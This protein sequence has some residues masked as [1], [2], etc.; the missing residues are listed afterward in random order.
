MQKELHDVASHIKKLGLAMLA[1]SLRHSLQEYFVSSNST[2]YMDSLGV[3]QAAHACE[4]LIKARIAEK[5]PLLIF[6]KQPKGEVPINLES[7]AKLGK[8]LQ[9]REL[10]KKLLDETGYQIEKS[11]LYQDFGDLRNAIQHFATPQDRDLTQETIEFIFGVIEPLI[12]DSWG[13]YATHHY[14]EDPLDSLGIFPTNYED[15]EPHNDI[16]NILLKL[17]VSFLVSDKYKGQVEKDRQKLETLVNTANFMRKFPEKSL[18][19][20]NDEMI[21]EIKIKFNLS[22]LDAMRLHSEVFH[23]LRS[24]TAYQKWRITPL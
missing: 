18:Y 2:S 1:H 5:D 8:T 21:K 22:E 4:I 17:N 19:I 9:Y 20:G 7:L 16:F 14:V 13:L 23:I 3:I 6:S 24:K 15:R 11:N 12:N 10:P